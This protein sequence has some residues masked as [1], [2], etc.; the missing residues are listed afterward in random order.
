M[1]TTTAEDPQRAPGPAGRVPIFATNVIP[2]LAGEDKCVVSR[3]LRDVVRYCLSRE[4]AL[5][6]PRGM[7]DREV[8]P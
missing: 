4:C 6:F 8:K 2:A 7:A 3:A 5:P 1:R